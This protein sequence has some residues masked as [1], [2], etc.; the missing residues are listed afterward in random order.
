[1]R[2]LFYSRVLR[3]MGNGCQICDDV[4]IAGA[5][6]VS[7]GCRVYLNDAVI[8]QSCDGAEIVVGNDVTLSYRACLITGGRKISAM[9]VQPGSHAAAPIVIEDFAWIGA[10]AI[11]LPGVTIGKGAVIAAGSVVTDDV[12]AGAIVGGVP[13]KVIRFVVPAGVGQP[14]RDTPHIRPSTSG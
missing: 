10:A 3:S 11:V 6:N 5:D 1:M 7:L 13:A 14:R 9:G 8:I 4:L 2:N 12:P